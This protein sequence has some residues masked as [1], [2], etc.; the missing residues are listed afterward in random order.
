[1]AQTHRDQYGPGVYHFAIPVPDLDKA[2]LDCRKKQLDV[3][4][5]RKGAAEPSDNWAKTINLRLI[6]KI[7]DGIRNFVLHEQTYTESRGRS[8]F[9]EQ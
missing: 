7:G 5:I 3:G 8:F 4:P 1:M 2:I 6:N 9:L